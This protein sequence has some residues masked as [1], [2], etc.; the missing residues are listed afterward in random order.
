M[1]TNYS[2]EL[3][4]AYLRAATEAQSEVEADIA[5]YRDFWDGWQGAVL[6]R[7]QREYLANPVHRPQ[8]NNQYGPI[9]H[10][11]PTGRQ[12]GSFAN[13]CR[14][15]V[16]IPGDRLA[17]TDAGISPADTAADAYAGAV[18]GWWQANQLDSLQK[19][20]YAAA[21]RDGHTALVVAWDN[22]LK[23]PVFT[24]NL[25][26]DG[27]TGLIRFHWDNDGSLVAA[28]KRWPQWFG[29]TLT[30]RMR[31]NVYLP[32][33]I[34]RYLDGGAEGWQLMTE[35]EL[36]ADALGSGAPV[37]TRN[38]EPW[39]AR[40]GTPLGI[41][42][43][44]FD[45]PGGSELASIVNIQKLIN[46]GLGSFDMAVDHHGWPILVAAGLNLETDPQT[47]KPVAADFSTDRLIR[48]EI[49]G[50]VK[51]IEG[52]NLEQ[53]FQSGVMSWFKVAAFVKGW[54][55][56]L[57]DKTGQPPSGVALE[58]LEGALVAQVEHKQQVFGGAWKTAFE[59]GRRL[60]QLYTGDEL[61]GE[62]TLT[63]QS[64]KT[65]DR[66]ADMQTQKTKWEAAQIPIITRW[67]ELGYTEDQIE[68]M[69]VDKQREDDLG[70][71]DT[72]TGIQQ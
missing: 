39:T 17:L 59:L 5:L 4:L 10:A 33:Q 23:R 35:E 62:L 54:P 46:H 9:T 58:H 13:I 32:G 37:V 48:V 25:V 53:M 22:T 50:D 47:G 30:G 28:S 15:V 18:T 42:V 27:G 43:I 57:F 51:R 7:R 11:P 31:L 49:G 3:R 66:A 36:R 24:P 29:L 1:P 20:L 71:A 55:Y 63:W 21:L 19:D 44:P 64:A 72:V 38:P 70:L 34:E 41:P 16:D 6:T 68:K 2:D 60:H 52:A 67:R 8:T 56:F 69:L 14:R 12:V 45:N 61:P 40:D 65:A 26:Y